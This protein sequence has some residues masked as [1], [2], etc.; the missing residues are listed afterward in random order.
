M[1]AIFKEQD[2]ESVGLDVS[3]LKDKIDKIKTYGV[4]VQNLEENVKKDMDR[5]IVDF[6]KE[7]QL[8]LFTD[9]AMDF[10]DLLLNFLCILEIP[11]VLNK[12]DKQFKFF[13]IDEYQDTNTIQYKIIKALATH[14]R[15]LCVI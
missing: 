9:N 2:L 14:T 7:Y 15:N 13:F 8:R 12:F 5:L 4:S 10:N 6:Y 1:K 11:E 3:F